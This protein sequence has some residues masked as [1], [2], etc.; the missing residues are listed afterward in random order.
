M[1]AHVFT[2]MRLMSVVHAA[3]VIMMDKLVMWGFVCSFFFA[4]SV[5][6]SDFSGGWALVSS[7]DGYILNE[8][9]IF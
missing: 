4:T 2:S 6:E 5:Q 1:Y 7:F 3:M 9:H 8:V